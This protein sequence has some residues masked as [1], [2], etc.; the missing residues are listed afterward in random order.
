LAEHDYVVANTFSAAG[1]Q[2]SFV[3]DAGASRGPLADFDNL[4]RLKERLQARPADR[5][6]IARGGPSMLGG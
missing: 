4:V 5:R 1:I 2:F 6:A 3:L